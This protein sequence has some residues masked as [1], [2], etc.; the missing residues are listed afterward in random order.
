VIM[1][2]FPDYIL[3]WPHFISTPS[4]ARSLPNSAEER[5][6]R[7]QI[8]M[9]AAQGRYNAKIRKKKMEVIAK[10]NKDGLEAPFISTPSVARSLPKSAEER[11]LRRQIQ[12]RA[13]RGR[14]NA[15]IR[16]SKRITKSE[17][18]R[19]SGNKLVV[20]NPRPPSPDDC[21]STAG[22]EVFADTLPGEEICAAVDSGMVSPF[23]EQGEVLKPGTVLQ[24]FPASL[25]EMVP[26]TVVSKVVAPIAFTEI[27]HR[28]RI[29]QTII[30]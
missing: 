3:P 11:K 12:M 24:L 30:V 15:K 17:D 20:R 9:R 1:S 27:L 25:E 19:R 26:A 10:A 29:G 23:E 4:V 28:C 2:F 21:N 6:L 18:D 22:A 13:A 8:Q 14:Y 16:K 7:R 5:K